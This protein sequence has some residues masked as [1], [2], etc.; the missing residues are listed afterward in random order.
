MHQVFTQHGKKR[1]R[2]MHQ[3]FNICWQMVSCSFM[4]LMLYLPLL[5]ICGLIAGYC[6]ASTLRNVLCA[7]CALYLRSAT[8]T[9]LLTEELVVL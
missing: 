5:D 9:T 6:F 1:K 2:L 8:Y 3:F 7:F 4:L